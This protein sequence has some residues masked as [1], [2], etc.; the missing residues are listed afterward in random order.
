MDNTANF[1]ALKAAT[2]GA[3]AIQSP[4]STLGASNAPELAALYQSTFQLPQSTGAA[5][6]AGNVAGDIEEE[7]RR[8]AAAAKKAAE[9]AAQKAADLADPKKYR[10]VKKD[11]GGYDFF[12][13]DGSQVDIATLAQRTQTKPSEWISDSENPIDVQYLEESANLNKYINA[14]L[15][16]NKKVYEAYEEANPELK[17]FQGKG[18]VDQLIKLFKKRYERYYVPRSV[19]PNAWGTRPGDNPLVPSSNIDPYAID[20][21]DSGIGG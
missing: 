5:N 12:A 8:A 10:V 14:K 19:N 2:L 17:K 6:S 9:E 3:Q 7:K 4:T 13:P 21:S 1:E 16:K 18:G 11:D 15:S 20:G